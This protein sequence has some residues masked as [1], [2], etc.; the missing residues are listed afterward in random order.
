MKSKET[1]N[2]QINE[3][4]TTS[5]DLK[6][7]FR[8]EIEIKMG[9]KNSIN[10]ILLCCVQLKSLGGLLFSEGKWRSSGLRKRRSGRVTGRSRGEA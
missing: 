3:I 9:L 2:I 7:E 6:I 8:K 5:Q 1:T 4:M 10:P